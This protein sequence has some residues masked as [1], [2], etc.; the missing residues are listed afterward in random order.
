MEY[1]KIYLKKKKNSVQSD[2]R[3]NIVATTC[4][5]LP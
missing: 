2:N 1:T 4:T 5:Q 3:T